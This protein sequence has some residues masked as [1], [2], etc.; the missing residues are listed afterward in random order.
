MCHELHDAPE[1]AKSLCTEAQACLV[2]WCRSDCSDLSF[3]GA[4]MIRFCCVMIDAVRRAPCRGKSRTGAATGSNFADYQAQ[5]AGGTALGGLG[6]TGAA[7]RAPYDF[8]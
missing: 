7:V 8:Q 3:V 6:N 5:A 1:V 2:H 4:Q